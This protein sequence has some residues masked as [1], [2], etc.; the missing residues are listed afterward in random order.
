MKNRTGFP[1]VLLLVALLTGLTGGFIMPGLL[2][3][4]V[5]AAPLDGVAVVP[6]VASALDVVINEVA[7]GGTTANNSGEWIE[8]YNNTNIEIDLSNWMIVATDGSPTI[9]ISGPN[10]FIPAHGYFLLEAGND[11]A[12]PGITA[13]RTYTGT[14]SNTG[15]ILTLYDNDIPRNVIDTGNINGGGWDAGSGSPDFYTMERVSPLLPDSA[16][17]WTDSSGTPH[18]SR[19]DLELSIKMK[20][21]I[22]ATPPITATFTITVSNKGYGTATGVQVTDSIPA[23]LNFDSYTSSTGTYS[24]GVWN[25]G[26]IESGSDETLDITVISNDALTHMYSAEI[27]ASGQLDPDSIPGNSNVNEDD[28]DS[29]KVGLPI[30]TITNS[31]NDATPDVGNNVLFTIT[32]SNPSGP[33]ATNVVV[34]ALLPNGL[35]YISHSASVG[36]SYDDVTGLWN[37]G[38][39]STGTTVTV[40]ITATVISSGTKT[41]V[42]DVSSDQFANSSATATINATAGEA[43]LRLVHGD[44]SPSTSAV[45]QVVLPITLYNDGPY[46]A[47]NVEVK[48]LLPSGLAYV[49]YS[50]TLGSYSSSTGLWSI[51]DIPSFANATINITARVAS[52]GTSTKNFAEV[53]NSDQFD[54]DSIPGNGENGEDDNASMEVPIVDLSLTESVNISGGVAIFSINVTNSGPDGA[55]GVEVKTSLPDLTSIYTFVSYGSTDGNDYNSSTGIW[56]VGVLAEGGTETLVITTN[57]VGNLVANWVEVYASDQVDVD[58][59]PN[60]KSK[61]EDD[62][63]SAPRADLYLTQTVNNSVPDINSNVVFNITVGNLGPAGT[64]NVEVRDILPSGLTY[65]SYSASSGTYSSSTGIWTVGTLTSGATKTLNITAKVT[66]S[67]VRTNWAEV[68]KSDELDPDSTPG[69]G[70]TNEDDDASAEITSKRTV[71]INEVAWA[72]TASTLKDDQ[73]IELYNPSNTSITI[74]GWKLTSSSGNINITLSGS[75]SSGG[76]FLLER[77]DDFTV[78]DITANQI[79]VGA[80]SMSGE[81]LTLKDG[82]GNVIDTANGDGGAW[83]AGSTTTYGTM[84]RTSTSA[85]SDDSW[86]T[87]T[88]NKKNGKNANN[89]DILGTP[90][91]LNSQGTG[92][93]PTR[94]KTPIPTPT[95]I[96]PTP[97]IDHR[98]LINEVLARP[99]FDWNGDGRVDVYDEFIEIKNV[100]PIDVTLSGWKIDNGIIKEVDGRE[101]FTLPSTITL[102]PGERVVFYRTESNFPLSDAGAIIRLLN[103]KGVV[104][105]EFQYDLARTEDRSF[106]RIPD[107]G[108]SDEAWYEDCTPTPKLTNTREGSAPSMIGDYTS[109]VCN[110]PDSIP[111]DFFIAECNGRGANIWNDFFWDEFG[112]FDELMIP[113]TSS[114]WESFIK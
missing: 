10:A 6:F 51:D 82:S 53:W 21:I 27:T 43:D 24:A 80:M 55:T 54:P 105:D 89:G 49:S 112:W 18:N 45:D 59:V 100:T 64:T 77:D 42:S 8:L 41:Y 67:G 90:K 62:D 9:T 103:P 47:T 97:S 86:V 28:Y 14:L 36:T 50:S 48:D 61:T 12:A 13:D 17:S 73:W 98:L 22:G 113:D 20:N 68:W 57:I 35:Q 93:S 39:L 96:I 26:S 34:D 60:N 95:P 38:T 16:A 29:I 106:C 79:Y 75:I 88:G 4:P 66:T 44:P 78:S 56:D 2:D 107:G 5:S 104:Y 37:I 84:E 46:N 69:N 85:E 70:S 81:I 63:A 91:N 31:V 11:N 23:G 65:V 7:W 40:N 33:D 19:I 110:L 108:Y 94:T 32:V 71:V 30:L 87:N 72:G 52:S 25:L 58:S 99:G 76:Y 15:E 102:K 109:P 101:V 114:K 92:A 74:T 83:P 3:K 111:N 1:R